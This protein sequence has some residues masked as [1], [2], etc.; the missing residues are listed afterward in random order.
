VAEAESAGGN[1][2]VYAKV[3]DPQTRIQL[4]ALLEN[5]PGERV[6][7]T[8]YEVATADWDAGLWDEEVERMQ[9]TIDPACDTLIFWHVVDGKLVRTSLAGRFA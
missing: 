9:E 1:I 3:R 2:L 6:S 4:H 7:G 8:L 5:L